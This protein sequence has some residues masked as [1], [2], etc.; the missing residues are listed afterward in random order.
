M[1]IVYSA[2]KHTEIILPQHHPSTIFPIDL[3]IKRNTKKNRITK[4]VY[5]RYI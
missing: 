5:I 2:L 4:G 1:L 3:E